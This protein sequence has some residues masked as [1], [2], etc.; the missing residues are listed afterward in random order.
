MSKF[1]RFF[2]GCFLAG[3]AVAV[4]KIASGYLLRA[5]T[6]G[7]NRVRYFTG[8]DWFIVGDMH[9]TDEEF[10]AF[11]EANESKQDVNST[12]RALRLLGYPLNLD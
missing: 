7:G 1:V 9:M 11:S 8:E 6:S 10:R 4:Y 2:G 5:E 3:K 12:V